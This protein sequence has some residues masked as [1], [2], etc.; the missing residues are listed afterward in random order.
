MDIQW[1][2]GHMAKTR[3]KLID[4][5]RWVDIV[6]E[7]ADARLPMSSRNPLLCDLIGEKPKILLLNKADLADAQKT[8][9][10][11][12]KLVLES[13]TLAVSAS[14]GLGMKKIVPQ[15]ELLLAG[16]MKALAQKGVRPRAVR[17]MVV[18]IPNI[19]KSSLINRLTAGARAKTGNK[20]GVTR[21]SQWI[22]VHERVD[23]LDTPGMLWPKFEDQEAGR[24]LAVTGAIRDETF[25]VEELALWLL[26]WLK[27]CYPQELGRYGGQEAQEISLKML[28]HRRG[29]L[30][31]GGEVDDVKI[32]HILLKDFRDGK[33]ARVTLEEC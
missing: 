11:R 4:Q 24:R 14:T 18:G 10:W 25:D 8:D 30:I 9:R 2:P 23:L 22:R 20:P 27:T 13:T 29:C 15:I 26:E 16:K 5:L 33:I 32:A 3:K 6:L 17:V 1:F 21:D 12:S 31:G 7:V 19:G 28:G